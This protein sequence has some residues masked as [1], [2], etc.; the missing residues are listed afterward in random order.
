MPCRGSFDPPNHFHTFRQGFCCVAGQQE[1][2]KIQTRGFKLQIIKSKTENWDV[3]I[4]SPDMS[5]PSPIS[6]SS[7]WQATAG[8]RE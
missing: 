2:K 6:L 3:E 7:L 8:Y 4:S 1:A 5:R